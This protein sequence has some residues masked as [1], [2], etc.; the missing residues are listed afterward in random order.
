M[1]LS[2]LLKIHETRFMQHRLNFPPILNN[3]LLSKNLH[4]GYNDLLLNRRNKADEVKC[5]SCLDI[6]LV[7][8]EVVQSKRNI[9][10]IFVSHSYVQ[11][12]H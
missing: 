8:N 12:C 11:D 9:E 3:M 7:F 4:L 2:F 10:F 1:D 6:L 5:T